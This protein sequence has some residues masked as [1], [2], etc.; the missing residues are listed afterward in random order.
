MWT[1]V[2]CMYRC[3]DQTLYGAPEVELT[4]G[5]RGISNVKGLAKRLIETLVSVLIDCNCL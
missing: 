5:R 2:C 3:L 4:T 1:V